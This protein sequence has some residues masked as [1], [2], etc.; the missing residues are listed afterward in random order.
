MQP[1]TPVLL[2]Q[3]QAVES[4]APALG[5]EVRRLVASTPGELDA[6]FTAT[7]TDATDAIMRSSNRPSAW[8]TVHVLHD[9]VLAS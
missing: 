2:D 8:I 1:R 3:T 6:V 7:A 9:P 5:V 4:A